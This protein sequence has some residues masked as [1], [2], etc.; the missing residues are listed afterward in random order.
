MIEG[1]GRLLGHIT[2]SVPSPE[3]KFELA[4]VAGA[5]RFLKF[6]GASNRNQLAS[7]DAEGAA[8]GT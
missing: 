5:A 1:E 4:S 3:G 2:S 6:Y 7:R 8:T